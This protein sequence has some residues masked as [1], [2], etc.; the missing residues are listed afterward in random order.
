[1]TDGLNM[2]AIVNQYTSAEAAVKAITAGADLLLMPADFQAAYEGVLEAVRNG[3][4]SEKRIDESVRR[5]LELKIEYM[6]EMQ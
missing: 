2:G 6:D 3:D 1:M 4:I 5:I